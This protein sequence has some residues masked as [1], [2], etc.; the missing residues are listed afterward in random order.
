MLVG[1]EAVGLVGVVVRRGD[2][3]VFCVVFVF[4]RVVCVFACVCVCG[5]HRNRIGRLGGR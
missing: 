3:S 5:L 1:V 4:S 2:A